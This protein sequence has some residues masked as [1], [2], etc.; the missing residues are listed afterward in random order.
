MSTKSHPQR[1]KLQLAMLLIV[2]S[3]SLFGSGYYLGLGLNKSQSAVPQPETILLSEHK[4]ILAERS[5]HTHLGLPSGTVVTIDAYP[6][7]EGI[8]V[9]LENR[10]IA[11]SVTCSSLQ[12]DLMISG[13]QIP[14]RGP[15]R[16]RGYETGSS[17]LVT[18]DLSSTP[19][20]PKR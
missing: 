4:R 17:F 14:D 13:V 11:H 5:R 6:Y 3:C 18:E 15:L 20:R 2:F 10:V 12:Y 7:L 9:P 8:E 16:Y 1:R 19:S